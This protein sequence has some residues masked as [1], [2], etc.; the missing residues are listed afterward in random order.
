MFYYLSFSMNSPTPPVKQTTTKPRR[1]LLVGWDAADWNVIN[2]LIAKGEMPT[3]AKLMERGS[4]GSLETLYPALSPMMWTSIATGKRPY[5]HGIHGFSEPDPQGAGV[6]P[7]TN[8]SRKTKAIWNILQHQGMRSNVIGWWPSHPVEPI[9]GVMVSNHYH[10]THS[11]DP[12]KPLPLNKGTVHPPRLREELAKLRF[13]P[14]ELMAEHI[15]PF[16]PKAAEIDLEKD[17][18]IGSVAKILAECITVNA[19]ATAVIQNEP[20]EFSAVYL[21]AIDHFS[22]GF[23]RYHPPRQEWIDEADFELYM[24]VVAGGYRF[25]DM[26]LEALLSLID[27]DTAVMLVSDHG[28]HP[29]HL[30][31]REIPKE[32]AGPVVEHSPYGMFVMAGPGIAQGK[33]LQGAS[34]LDVTPTILQYYGLPCGKDMDGRV[35][36]EIF[37]SSDKIK[38]IPSW[39]EVEGECG[40][41]SEEFVID[42]EEAQAALQQLVALGYIDEPSEEVGEAI[43]E[44]KREL[45]YN[46]ARSY[47]DGHRHF[48]AI[49]IL[50]ECW[51]LYPKESRF[52][53]QLIC[54]HVALEQT[55]QARAALNELIQK[56]QIAATAAEKEI[57]GLVEQWQADDIKFTD[58]D[59][60]TTHHFS[61]LQAQAAISPYAAKMLEGMVVFAEKDY[62]QALSVYTEAEPF[63]EKRPDVYQRMGQVLRLLERY[64][65]AISRFE[66]A[67][68]LDKREPDAHLGISQCQLKLGNVEAA[69][70]SARAALAS[71]YHSPWAHFYLAAALT[72]SK[73]AK[74]AVTSLSTAL[75]LNPNFPRAHAALAKIYESPVLRDAVKALHHRQLETLTQKSI[76]EVKQ[77][78]FKPLPEAVSPRKAALKTYEIPTTVRVK[79]TEKTLDPEQVITI[80]TGLP[81]SG[82]SMMMNMLQAAGLDILTDELRQADDN[83]PLGYFEYKPATSLRTNRDW[84]PKAR[85]KVVKV[86]A[87]LLPYLP[88]N[89][90]Y[91]II[92]MERPLDEVLL[93]Q[94]KMLQ[95]SDA[96]SDNAGLKNAFHQQLN[97]VHSY[98]EQRDSAMMQVPFSQCIA[99][100]LNV[101]GQLLSYLAIDD[102]SAATVGERVNAQLYRSKV[103]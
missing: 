45:R 70:A 97:R 74:E 42:P 102:I 82:T 54:C 77:G 86:V 85:G 18:R 44:T 79:Q 68:A 39:D 95:K 43:A 96:E 64:E 59:K 99:E 94:Q 100:P 67:L 21:D 24:D 6:R 37:E 12:E 5:K 81:R 1:L 63:N 47:M 92:F 78:L 14:A 60:K 32:A 13:H 9:D 19:A 10:N 62:P 2:P 49:P 56:K 20:W 75:E 55:E 33:Q 66:E 48:D 52:G 15:L 88:T 71:R 28:F 87:Q 73:R 83:N 51:D 84:V 26:M 58:L 8:I 61:Q 53:T 80:V 29:D 101:A 103:R 69:E 35:L 25:H 40:L 17:K 89:E 16:V 31:P 41:H 72:R 76:A 30:R 22:H 91:R 34:L 98:V 57:K 23:M 93:S 46:L 65:E 27:E 50:R 7:V 36:D 4:S 3:L 38:P 11:A 90:Q